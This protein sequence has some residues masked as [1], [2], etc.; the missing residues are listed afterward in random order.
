MKQKISNIKEVWR[1]TLS[2]TNTVIWIQIQNAYLMIVK[3]SHFLQHQMKDDY[4]WF[5]TFQLLLYC[6]PVSKVFH[7]ATRGVSLS[8]DSRQAKS[9][10]PNHKCLFIYAHLPKYCRKYH[11]RQTEL[12][13][14]RLVALGPNK[15]QSMVVSQTLKYTQ[16]PLSL[17]HNARRAA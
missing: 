3:M 12:A 2:V 7:I 13:G 8:V 4:K 15:S 16:I 17:K 14:E 10:L 9:P 5:K 11:R 6:A 1:T